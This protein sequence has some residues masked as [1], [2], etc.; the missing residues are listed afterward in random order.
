MRASAYF[1]GTSSMF[2]HGVTGRRGAL[3][4]IREREIR[5]NKVCENCGSV[6]RIAGLR[7]PMRD[8][9]SIACEVCGAVFVQW[10]KTS[11]CYTAVLIRRRQAASPSAA[12]SSSSWHPLIRGIRASWS[13]W[14]IWGPR[15]VV[16]SVPRIEAN[17]RAR[18]RAGSSSAFED[19]VRRRIIDSLSVA[20]I[21]PLSGKVVPYGLPRLTVARLPG[22]TF[23][24]F[25]GCGCGF[26]VVP[27]H[28]VAAGHNIR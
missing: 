2:V 26:R 11:K 12:E 5:M 25:R 15:G 16:R 21:T 10:Q 19:F 27:G 8:S 13:C 6:Y 1:L 23:P 22:H 18:S 17:P 14:A 28:F 7:I 24:P 3:D 9:G 4:T 20:S